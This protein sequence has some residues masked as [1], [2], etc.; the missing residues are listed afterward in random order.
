[1]SSTIPRKALVI[2]ILI[3]A[4]GSLAAARERIGRQKKTVPTLDS[5]TKLLVTTTGRVVEGQI[6]PHAGGYMVEMDHGS[7]FMP[8]AQVRLQASSRNDAYQKLRKSMPE[9]SATNHV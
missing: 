6:I 7:L 4:A 2:A 5:S 8:F 3:C 1:M 9:L